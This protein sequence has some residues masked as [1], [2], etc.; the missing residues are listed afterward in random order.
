MPAT[1]MKAAYL[2][3]RGSANDLVYGDLPRPAPSAGEVLVNV[4]A[5]TVMPTEPT[6]SFTW[7]TQAGSARPFPIILG[8]EFSGV[9]AALGMGVDGLAVGD[10]VY[11][12]NDWDRQGAQAEYC[13][14]RP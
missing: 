5:A 10:A 12:L 1:T 13:L 6:W 14:T 8:H 7:E 4:H 2:E 9:I 3:R 11:G